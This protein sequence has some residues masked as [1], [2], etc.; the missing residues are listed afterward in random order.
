MVF[1]TIVVGSIPAI[2]GIRKRIWK[3]RKTFFTEIDFFYF[4][5]STSLFNEKKIFF[6]KPTHFYLFSP[7]I[8]TR[9][10]FLPLYTFFFPLAFLFKKKT[11]KDVNFLSFFRKKS[12][13]KG[14]GQEYLIFLRFL[15]WFLGKK[16]L[17]NV[18][19]FLQNKLPIID[20]SR[21][22]LWENRLRGFSW[23]PSKRFSIRR[24]FFLNLTALRLKDINLLFFAWHNLFNRVDFWKHRL[25]VHFVRYVFSSL[26]NNLFS[27]LKIKGFRFFLKGKISV[28]G[29]SR[30]RSASYWVGRTSFSNKQ[31]RILYKFNII[32]TW[33]GAMGLHLWLIF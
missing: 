30:K 27:D 14:W 7:T 32:P 29:N 17:L 26:L 3:A 23:L 8:K 5:R 22:I 9:G 31:N 11:V 16:I 33:T 25:V 15:E 1:K 13:I 20:Y 21:C 18:F 28:S 4:P 10:P 6:K 19:V 12:T 2:L 24:F